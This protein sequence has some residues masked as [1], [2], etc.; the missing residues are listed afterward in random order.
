[1]PGYLGSQ[2]PVFSTYFSIRKRRKT[3][4]P[5]LPS[6]EACVQEARRA[7]TPSVRS[8]KYKDE[9]DQSCEVCLDPPSKKFNGFLK[10]AHESMAVGRLIE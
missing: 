5:V 8:L 7:N 4:N 10:D 2:T 3:F 1:M 9:A 6:P